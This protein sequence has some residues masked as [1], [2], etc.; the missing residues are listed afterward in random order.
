MVPVTTPKE[1]VYSETGLMDIEH[2]IINKR[3]NM[4]CRLERTSNDLIQIILENDQKKSWAKNT[5]ETEN[6]IG[7]TDI[8]Q[9]DM[10]KQKRLIKQ[11]VQR[12][13]EEAIQKSGE[14]KSKVK[15]LMENKEEQ[16]YIVKTPKYMEEMT[17]HEASTIFKARTRMLEVK[18]NFRGKYNDN[19]CRLCEQT[20]ETQEH[21]L[22]NCGKIHQDENTQVRKQDIFEEDVKNLEETVKKIQK[23]MNILNS[24]VLE[25]VQPG[26]PGD[27]TS[28]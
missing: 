19:K 6:N 8:L 12:D 3:I 13:F 11:A 5:S 24:A 21:I 27:S 16:I 14:P 25:N 26:Y 15:H 23:I 2:Y 20:D 10:T 22:E 1:A 9:K 7:L 17:R 4:H 28:E 18:N